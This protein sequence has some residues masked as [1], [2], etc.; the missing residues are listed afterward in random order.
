MTMRISSASSPVSFAAS[1][2]RANSSARSG[3]PK[4][5]SQSAI[6]G[7]SGDLLPILRAA[8]SSAMA[9]DQSPHW[10]AAIPT[11]SRTAAIRPERARAAR[12][13][14][15][16]AS[17][18]SSSNSPAAT[19]CR[20]TASALALSKVLSSRRISGASCLASISRGIGGPLWS[21]SEPFLGC[22]LRSRPGPEV[23]DWGRGDRFG[24]RSLSLCLSSPTRTLHLVSTSRQRIRAARFRP[25]Y[26]TASANRSTW[27]RDATAG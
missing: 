9:W 7:S 3:R 23:A 4:P 24:R 22:A 2:P 11:A 5:R 25:C 1:S 26:S 21:S 8:R 6:S 18:S 15:S 16:A 14:L 19:R 27:S 17:G 12:A 20:A 13:W 10:Y